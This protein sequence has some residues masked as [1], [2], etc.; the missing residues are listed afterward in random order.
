[1]AKA[2]RTSL[3]PPFLRRVSGDKPTP[4]QQRDYPFSIPFLKHGLDLTFDRPITIIVGDN[5]AG[6]STLLEAIA[7]NCGF[8]LMGGT[9]NHTNFNTKEESLAKHLRFGWT[10]RVPKGFFLRAETLAL[11]VDTI[12]RIAGDDPRILDAYGGKSLDVRSHGETFMALF[13]NQFGRQGIYILDEPEAALSP[14]R[15]LQFLRLLRRMED[16]ELCQLVIATHSPLLMAYPTARLLR[17]SDQGLTELEFHQT[18]NF[19]ILRDFYVD[20]DSFIAG[21]FMDDG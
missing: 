16:S 20:P 5:G 13:E 12:D 6:K 14:E 15:Q 8:S 11:F 19:R 4:A 1:M 3:K 18:K 2:F 9:R 21:L 10:P 17:V 7:E